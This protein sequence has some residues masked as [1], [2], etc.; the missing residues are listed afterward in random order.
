VPFAPL[1]LRPSQVFFPF[2]PDLAVL[3]PLVKLQI[4]QRLKKFLIELRLQLWA[5]LP[6]SLLAFW[7]EQAGSLESSPLKNDLSKRGV[8]ME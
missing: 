7:F 3:I 1:R 5:K 6:S 4:V 8:Q 2:L